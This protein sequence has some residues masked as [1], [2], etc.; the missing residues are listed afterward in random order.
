MNNPAPLGGVVHLYQNLFLT[1]VVS[2]M[3]L[4]P[5]VKGEVT[6]NSQLLQGALTHNSKIRKGAQ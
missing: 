5:A 4:W 2:S 1:T 3:L 6:R